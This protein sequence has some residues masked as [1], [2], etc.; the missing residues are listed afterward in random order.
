VPKPGKDVC[1]PLIEFWKNEITLRTTYAASPKD[2]K[3]ALELIRDRT[4]MVKDMITHTL[5]LK[6]ISVGFQM[7]AQV[8][9]SVKVIIQPYK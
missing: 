6:D 8:D 7:V 3:E 5:G 2:L 9:K 1:I 4:I